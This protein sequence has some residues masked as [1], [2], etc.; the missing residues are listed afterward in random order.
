MSTETTTEPAGMPDPDV[1]FEAIR[2]AA[3]EAMPSV[4]L[5]LDALRP[6]PL[7]SPLPPGSHLRLGDDDE[8]GVD[9]VAV[10][11][12][13]VGIERGE[14]MTERGTV[15]RLDAGRRLRVARAAR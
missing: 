7:W 14:V 13:P 9:V 12:W 2:S 1:A 10:R 4:G 11:S 3:W 8:R 5:I 6:D 15:V